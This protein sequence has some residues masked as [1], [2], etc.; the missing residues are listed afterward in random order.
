MREEREEEEEEE[1]EEF[2]CVFSPFP[3]LGSSYP[4]PPRVCVVSRRSLAS[5]GLS[6]RLSLPLSLSLSS[7]AS[8][9]Q[10]N[11]KLIGGGGGGGRT[12]KS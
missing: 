8:S 5:L 3:L 10:V 6:T 4:F 12:S 2:Y 7:H 1:E 11:D 9:H